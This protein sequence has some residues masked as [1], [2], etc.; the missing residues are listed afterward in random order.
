MPKNFV[1]VFSYAKKHCKK[2]KTRYNKSVQTVT[3]ETAARSFIMFLVTSE[4]PSLP[5]AFLIKKAPAEAGT[6][7]EVNHKIPKKVYNVAVEK[8]VVQRVSDSLPHSNSERLMKK[9][10]L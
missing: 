8:P 5:E 7:E 9:Q 10:H 1:T 4:K 2:E 3:H 6:E